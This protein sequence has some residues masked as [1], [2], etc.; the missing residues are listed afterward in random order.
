MAIP[1]HIRL[2]LTWVQIPI[3]VKELKTLLRF[4]G[5]LIVVSPPRCRRI[6]HV[7]QKPSHRIPLLS[8]EQ[9]GFAF[10]VFRFLSNP[11]HR[12][13]QPSVD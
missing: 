8:A 12:R 4:F 11:S 13:C 7:E 1:T 10:V 5:K 9:S 2:G 3:D 6:R